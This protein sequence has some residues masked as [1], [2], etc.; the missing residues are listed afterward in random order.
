MHNRS[1][2]PPLTALMI[3]DSDDRLPPAAAPEQMAASGPSSWIW[4]A[5]EGG[6][7]MTRPEFEDCAIRH[8]GRG[9]ATGLSRRTANLPA[10][11]AAQGCA[12]ND[13][14]QPNR[15]PS[16]GTERRVLA[17]R[18][19]AAA[20]WPGTQPVC[21][22]PGVGQ[23]HHR[24]ERGQSPATAIRATSRYLGSSVQ[25]GEATMA[26]NRLYEPSRRVSTLT[27]RISVP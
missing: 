20:R 6:T 27:L 22:V 2:L 21:C 7:A 19:G 8:P 25:R 12:I 16:F 4:D 18:P 13:A 23:H 11:G 15:T 24:G 26:D 9:D 1:W 5:L 14:G 3:G 10:A 17:W